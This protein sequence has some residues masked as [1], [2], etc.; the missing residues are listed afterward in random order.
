MAPGLIAYITR[1]RG[2]QPPA[3][4]HPR[5]PTPSTSPSRAL[6]S[7]SQNRNTTGIRTQLKIKNNAGG[8]GP[9]LYSQSSGGGDRQSS[10]LLSSR[11]AL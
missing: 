8:G 3:N 1:Y 6:S 4:S 9:H 5:N 11:P 2:L 7:Y 10:A